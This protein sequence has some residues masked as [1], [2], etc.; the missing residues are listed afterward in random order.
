M[1]LDYICYNLIRC[2][3][4]FI[5]SRK[6]TAFVGSWKHT[7]FSYFFIKN[8]IRILSSPDR[9]QIIENN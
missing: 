9:I 1:S 4:A 2:C 5:G 7:V 6:H 3:S 8:Q